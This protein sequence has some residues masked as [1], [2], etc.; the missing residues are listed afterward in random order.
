MIELYLVALLFGLWVVWFEHSRGIGNMTV[1]VFL[2]ILPGFNVIAMGI[3]FWEY[4]V[5][6]KYNRR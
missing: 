3:F 4:F 2:A 1:N 6:K 5:E